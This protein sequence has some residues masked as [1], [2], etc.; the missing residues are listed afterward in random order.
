MPISAHAAVNALLA[1]VPKLT[2][3]AKLMP[4]AKF[5][6]PPPE[7]MLH[8]PP[9]HAAVAPVSNASAL[10]DI[11]IMRSMRFFNLNA[12]KRLRACTLNPMVSSIV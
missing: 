3:T 6:S 4:A 5:P 7:G 10:A 2:L 12:L 1:S 11:A 8:E 9:A